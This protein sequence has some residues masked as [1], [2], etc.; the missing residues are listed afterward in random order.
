MVFP[1]RAGVLASVVMCWQF[2]NEVIR[3]TKLQKMSAEI[4]K[5]VLLAA[6]SGFAPVIEFLHGAGQSQLVSQ[7]AVLHSLLLFAFRN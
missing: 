2:A 6:L 5:P 4:S 1:S 7:V 3:G